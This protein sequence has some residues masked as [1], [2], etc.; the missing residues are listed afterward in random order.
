LTRRSCFLAASK[1]WWRSSHARRSEYSVIARAFAEQNRG[2]YAF[3]PH[4]R[5]VSSRKNAFPSS[6]MLIIRAR[7]IAT[8]CRGDNL[9]DL[10]FGFFSLLAL[11]R[12]LIVL[13]RRAIV[14][15]TVNR[16]AGDRSNASCCGGKVRKVEGISNRD[17]RVDYISAFRAL[18]STANS[19]ALFLPFLLRTCRCVCANRRSKRSPFSHAPITRNYHCIHV[20]NSRTAI[21]FAMAIAPRA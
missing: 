15:D 1:V 17:K 3:P 13:V 2:V 18:A 14:N 21:S 6:I 12:L 8:S 20:F 10:R 7:V 9:I 4:T 16:I 19:L 5:D 11:S